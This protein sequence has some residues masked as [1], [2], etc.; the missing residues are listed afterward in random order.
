MGKK[1]KIGRGNIE[2]TDLAKKISLI[3]LDKET[4]YLIW[5]DKFKVNNEGNMTISTKDFFRGKKPFLNSMKNYVL[6][7]NINNSRTKSSMDAVLFLLLTLNKY[8]LWETLYEI[9]LFQ[10]QLPNL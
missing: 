10:V 1:I 8:L 4:A 7:G 5:W 9:Y 3:A 6:K 2:R